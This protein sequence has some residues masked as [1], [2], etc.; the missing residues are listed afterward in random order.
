MLY[1]TPVRSFRGT[2]ERLSQCWF[3]QFSQRVQAGAWTALASESP[4]PALASKLGRPWI[5]RR[6]ATGGAEPES[7]DS[8]QA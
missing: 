7:E 2:S 5:G 8:S 3:I 4:G 1:M 6:S